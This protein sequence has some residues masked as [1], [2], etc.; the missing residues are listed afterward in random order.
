MVGY[1]VSA[2][3]SIWLFP[4]AFEDFFGGPGLHESARKIFA[5]TGIQRDLGAAIGSQKFVTEYLGKKIAKWT[6]QVERLA[7]IA[8]TQPHAAFVFGIRNK[9]SYSQRTMKGVEKFMQPLE[10]ATRTKF[11]PAL[12]GIATPISEI[13]RELYALPAREGGLAVDNPVTGSAQKHAD[14]KVVTAA[15]TELLI[16]C[17][18][19]LLVDE[20]KCREVKAP[21]K[22]QRRDFIAAESKRIYEHVPVDLQRALIFAKEKWRR[23]CLQL[24]H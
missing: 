1:L 8:M 13:V 18:P 12:L 15:L 2:W 24:G 14:S 5:G 3:S 19:A 23:R 22:K 17:E 10:D 4:Q 21:I 11:L 7:E 6:S 20:G 16:A 9:W